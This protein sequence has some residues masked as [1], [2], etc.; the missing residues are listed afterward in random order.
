MFAAV[1]IHRIL[2]IVLSKLSSRP[3]SPRRATYSVTALIVSLYALRMVQRSPD[4][5]D[6]ATLH[7]SSLSVCPRSA[8]LNLQVDYMKF[9]YWKS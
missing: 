4:W 9:N 1:Y 3:L 6:D 7:L 8:K 2:D 5:K